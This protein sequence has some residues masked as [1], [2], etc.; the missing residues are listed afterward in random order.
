MS[1]EHP[2]GRTAPVLATV[3]L[4][5]EGM[6]C[7]SCVARVER[8][9]GKIPGVTATVNLPLESAHVELTSDVP[10]SELIEAV[11]AAGYSA[12][13]V[14]RE[15]RADDGASS[16]HAGHGTSGE[17]AH[18]GAGD[19]A[20]HGAGTHADPTSDDARGEHTGAGDHAGAGHDVEHALAGH[21]MEGHGDDPDADTS[22]PAERRGQDLRRRLVLA[23]WLTPVTLLSM[24]PAWQFPG[25]QWLVAAATLPVVTWA[26]WPF[27]RAAFKAARHGASTMDT[28]VSLGVI[29][30]TVWSLWALLLGGAGEIG[31][32]MELTLW[33]AAAAHGSTAAPELYFEVA[34]V[35]TTFLLLGRFLEH[36]S[37]RSA[38]DALRTLLDL[39]AKDATRLETGPGGERVETLVPVS[40]LRIDDLFTVRPGEKVATDGVVVEGRSAVDAS[41]LTGE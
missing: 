16:G 34:A 31:M 2:T 24:I 18:H 38:G 32:R 15:S 36:R 26:A 27:H 22:S 41:L 33:P 12:R 5:V 11:E 19:H 6:T 29:A 39:G 20:H 40:A 17:H 25:W 21:S 3:D 28:L 7:A 35:V 13:V 4:E 10:T 9:L 23:A 8:R 14:A 1:T 37:R 30:A